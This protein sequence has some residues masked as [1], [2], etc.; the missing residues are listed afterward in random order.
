MALKGL[1]T[2]GQARD[3]SGA[4]AGDSS[5]TH[6]ATLSDALAGLG[7][8]PTTSVDVGT[9]LEGRLRCKETLHVDGTIRG[10]V[11]CENAVIVSESAR[12]IAHV[13]AEEV[14]VA[15]LVEGDIAARRKITLERTAVV[16]GDLTTP[17]IVIEEGAKLKG[18]IVIDSDALEEPATCAVSDP[19]PVA[20]VGSDSVS[21][22]PAELQPVAVR[23]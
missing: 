11:E 23:A 8:A 20:D 12:V 21:E 10:E 5:P 14:W 6:P 7:A 1:M 19:E 15:G 18:R 13:S 3:D 22:A 9:E 2:R 17:G 16:V 4:A